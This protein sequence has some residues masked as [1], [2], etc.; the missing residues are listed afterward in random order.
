MV[1]EVPSVSNPPLRPQP[2][3]P[4]HPRLYLPAHLLFECLCSVWFPL[5]FFKVQTGFLV[6]SMLCKSMHKQKAWQ[7]KESGVRGV[8]K[9]GDGKR[10]W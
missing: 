6:F 5:D 1:K 8:G 2:F 3:P 7:W 10:L 4:H 9:K